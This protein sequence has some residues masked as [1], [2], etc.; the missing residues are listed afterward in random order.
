MTAEIRNYCA[1]FVDD[2]GSQVQF[3]SMSSPIGTAT[4]DGDTIEPK[5]KMKVPAGGYVVLWAAEHSLVSFEQ[6]GFRIIGDGALSVWWRTD[7]PTSAS[8]PTALGTRKR[9]HNKNWPCKMAP[10]W[11]CD[12]TAY[13]HATIANENDDDGGLPKLMTTYQ[14]TMDT[15]IIDRLVLY[16]LET[17]DI[18]IERFFAD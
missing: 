3:G 16:N 7:L 13:G 17:T 10:W 1:V 5:R 4:I 8:D 18:V 6:V 12:Q 9:W 15:N 11:L 14:S 2:S